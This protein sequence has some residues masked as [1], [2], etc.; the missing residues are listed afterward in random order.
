MGQ[1]DF[2]VQYQHPCPETGIPNITQQTGAIVFAHAPAESSILGR[3]T[4]SNETELISQLTNPKVFL[5]R[6]E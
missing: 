4:I 2:H 6:K 1:F 5:R 3:I